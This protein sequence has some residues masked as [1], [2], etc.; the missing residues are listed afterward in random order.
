MNLSGIIIHIYAISFVVQE[1]ILKTP[2]T[3]KTGEPYLKKIEVVLYGETDQDALPLEG[4]L[5]QAYE[6]AQEFCSLLS[7]RV[8]A[9]ALCP[10]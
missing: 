8:K 4:Y 2:S 3:K 1:N 9:V 7:Q 5:R 10:H 6:K